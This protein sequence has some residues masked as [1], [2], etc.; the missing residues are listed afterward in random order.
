MG[1]GTPQGSTH[2]TLTFRSLVMVQV[3]EKYSPATGNS[4]E[5]VMFTIF[6]TSVCQMSKLAIITFTF[7]Y[8]LKIFYILHSPT[9][10]PLHTHTH[11]YALH[12]YTCIYTHTHTAHTHNTH[13]QTFPFMAIQLHFSVIESMLFDVKRTIR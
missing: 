4:V 6:S 8:P 7:T 1:H 2:D 11:T 5:A 12:V 9:Y 13:I 3:R 10:P